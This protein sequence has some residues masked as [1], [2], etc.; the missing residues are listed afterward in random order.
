MFPSEVEKVMSHM[1]QR[2]REV[3][4]E[5]KMM[6]MEAAMQAY[7]S[8][9]LM[10]RALRVSLPYSRPVM[11]IRIGCNADQDPDADLDQ[12]SKTKKLL[13]KIMQNRYKV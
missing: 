13:E 2:E 5:L 10:T 1:S 9:N 12:G 8:T 11:W 7:T 3:V 4:A 6:A